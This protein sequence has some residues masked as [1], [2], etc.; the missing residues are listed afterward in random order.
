MAQTPTPIVERYETCTFAG[1]RGDASLRG[2]PPGEPERLAPIF[3]AIDP[4]ARLGYRPEGLLRYLGTNERG[5]PRYAVIVGHEVVGAVGLRLNWLKGPYLQFL[6]IVPDYQNSA[7]GSAVVNWLAGEARAAGER[8]VWVCATSFNTAAL[9][10]YLR[11]G[12]EPVAEIDQL[13]TDDTSEVLL[14]RRL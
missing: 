6:G 12:F 11:H 5:A 14:R 8:N 1:G 3:S 13:L 4:W 7:L 9:R 10:F 2:M